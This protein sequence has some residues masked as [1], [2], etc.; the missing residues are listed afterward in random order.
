MSLSPSFIHNKVDL[1]FPVYYSDIHLLLIGQSTSTPTSLIQRE[2]VSTSPPI[3]SLAAENG[4]PGPTPSPTSQTSSDPDGAPTKPTVT[5]GDRQTETAGDSD[6]RSD[7]AITPRMTTPQPTHAHTV[8]SV[9]PSPDNIS[10]SLSGNQ[11][12]QKKSLVFCYHSWIS[13]IES[14]LPS[15]LVCRLQLD[16]NTAW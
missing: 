4:V 5:E 2:G 9:T 11:E 16:L 13:Y 12:D 8:N 6:D 10:I 15:I 1:F 3:L 7:M 14:V